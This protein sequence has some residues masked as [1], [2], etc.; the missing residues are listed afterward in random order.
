MFSVI[1]VYVEHGRR[2]RVAPS[3]LQNKKQHSIVQTETVKAKTTVVN[4]NAAAA[5]FAFA[6][7]F[8]RG[9]RVKIVRRV[10]VLVQQLQQE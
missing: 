5:T 7:A 6:V 4:F 10:P 2:A 3:A 1:L 9:V 8:V